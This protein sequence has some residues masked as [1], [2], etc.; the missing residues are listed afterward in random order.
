MHAAPEINRGS[1]LMRLLMLTVTLS[2]MTALM[3][4][5]VLPQI[6]EEFRLSYAQAGWLSAGYTIL[7]AFG[8]VTYGKLAD[9]YRLKNL[10]SIGL[11]LFAA[12]SL[13]GLVSF[14]Y[15]TA[16]AGR[17][18]QA[19]G[20]SCIPAMAMIVPTRYFPPERRGRAMAMSAVGVALGGALAPIVSSLIVSAFHWRWLFAP[21]LITLSLLPFFRKSLDDKPQKAHE[22]FDW[23]GGGLLAAAVGLFLLGTTNRNGLLMLAG[24][25]VLTLFVL[26]I[27]TAAQ[28]FIRPALFRNKRYSL[29][30]LLSFLIHAVGISLH[31]L[32]PKLLSDANGL[33]AGQIGMAMVP[34]ALAAAVL[35]RKGGKLAD[36]KGN[37]FLFRIASAS[38]MAC[39]LLLSAFAGVSPFWIA[40]FLV[41]GSVGQS[42]I[43]VAMANTISRTLPGDQTGVGMGLFSMLNFIAQGLA[44]GVYGIAVEWH[45]AASWNPVHAGADGSIY[46]NL[47]L[48]LAVL[49]AAILTSY[50]SW[51]KENQR[52]ESP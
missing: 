3:F 32:T 22:P 51:F 42:F 34:A 27:R 5:I 38:L 12:G 31:V 8:T 11:V 25:A 44:V 52:G 47:Y 17:C 30:L 10:L 7:Y 43:G 6:S 26:R 15:W 1:K 16:L 37:P 49:H 40:A 41:F 24:F 19:I 23:L 4:N 18:L 29:A 45:A 50:L 46:S 13:A 33:E 35:G 28:P 48:V 36:L 2:S 9:R 20:A 21:P 14:S 39:F